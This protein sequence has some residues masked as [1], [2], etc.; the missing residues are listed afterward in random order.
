MEHQNKKYAGVSPTI[1]SSQSVQHSPLVTDGFH[2]APPSYE[3]STGVGS[4]GSAY[5]RPSHRQ[6][7][8]SRRS[9]ASSSHSH[10]NLLGGVSQPPA[11]EPRPSVAAASAPAP[12]APSEL[13]HGAN[14]G[15]KK[16]DP[17][18]W[19]G[20]TWDEHVGKPGCCGSSS[21]GCCFSSRGACCFS[22]REACCFS[23]RQG[24]CFSDRGGCCCG[25]L[26]GACCSDG[27]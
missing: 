20:R 27:R 13:D 15:Y 1:I 22:D 17:M 6:D 3:A 24:C 21:G 23:D 26:G 12:V 11:P 10:H 25:D 7:Y 4:T 9:S 14:Q 19:E 18:Y 8:Q 16:N 5:S 2:D